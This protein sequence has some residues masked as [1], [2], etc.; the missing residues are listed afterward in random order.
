MKN[1][2]ILL[3]EKNRSSMGFDDEQIIISS[4][5]HKS[6]E[7]LVAATEKSNLL[8]SQKI[9]PISAV[10]AISYNQKSAVLKIEYKTTKGTIKK[11][12]ITLEHRSV[13]GSIAREISAMKN[14][15]QT[16]IAESRTKPLLQYLLIMA[17]IILF[18]WV[19]LDI[20][21]DAQ[22]G[23]RYIASGRRSGLKQLIGDGIAYI[24]P[25]GVIVIGC[26]AFGYVAF[27]A[28]QRYQAPASDIMYA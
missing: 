18:G 5:N 4:K 27:L 2:I 3:N 24:G 28:Y 10:Q 23:E 19:S 20:A 16:E 13:C 1:K 22:N 21:V 15:E 12:R 11:D 17:F 25:I 7:A 6:F 14:F 9:I 26:I 8:S